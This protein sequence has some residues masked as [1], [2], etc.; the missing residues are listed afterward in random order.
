MKAQSGVNS[1]KVSQGFNNCGS[2]ERCPKERWSDRGSCLQGRVHP[3]G[4]EGNGR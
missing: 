1:K 4:A 3:L 2:Y